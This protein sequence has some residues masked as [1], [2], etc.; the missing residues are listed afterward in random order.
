MRNTHTFSYYQDSL[1]SYDAFDRL[2]AEREAD[3]DRRL[4]LLPPSKDPHAVAPVT[5]QPPF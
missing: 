5:D 2:D 3:E 4:G 1:G